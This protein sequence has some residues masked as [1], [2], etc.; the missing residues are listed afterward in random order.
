M[1]VF[2]IESSCDETAAAIIEDHSDPARRILSNIV[3][4]QWD[5]HRPYGGIVPGNRRPRPC[6]PHG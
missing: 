1:R 6:P 5:E 4:S 3:L 2:G